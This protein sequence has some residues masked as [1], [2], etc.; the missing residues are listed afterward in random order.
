MLSDS[1]DRNTAESKSF[2]WRP[3]LLV[4]FSL[5][6]V[7]SLLAACD[8]G[9]SKVPNWVVYPEQEWLKIT[10][11]QAGFDEG[12]FNQIISSFHA[13]GATF[14]G[15]SHNDNK[16]GAVLI[17]GGY[18]V[19]TWG[20]PDY[21]YQSASLG[22]AFTW[23]AFGLAVDEGLV[24]PDDLINETW[25]GEGL[26]SHPHKNLNEGF[27]RYLTWRHLLTHTGGFPVTNGYYWTK[28]TGTKI[29]P[30]PKWAKPSGDPFYD[31]YSHA[32]PGTVKSYSSGGYWRLAQALTALWNKDIK[33]VLDEKLFNQMGIPADQWDWTPGGVV[34]NT[35][36]WYP[37]M[38]GYGDFVDPP[39]EINGQV[40]RGGP[41]WVVMSPKDLA[42]FGL[43]ISTGGIW[44][45]RRLISSQWVRGHAGGNGS[46]VT[47]DQNT[48]VAVAIVTAK[49]VP[50]KLFKEAIIGP[51]MVSQEP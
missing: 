32:R 46:L 13:K 15:E 18:L 20:N 1:I 34:Q 33:Q 49:G 25:S 47:G 17:R 21:K 37:D 39:Y 7:V 6:S 28:G 42:R 8:K 51:V 31:N 22:K 5:V 4:L 11:E 23:A 16:W 10:P 30:F 14:G 45:G 48:Y 26:F 38:P 43:L 9:Q 44:K 50:H 24:E 40:V 35:R 27:H 12:R 3:C 29:S 36:D 41:G 2:S 19:H